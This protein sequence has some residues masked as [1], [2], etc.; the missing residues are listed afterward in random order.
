MELIY[1]TIDGREFD[2]EADA[3]YHESVLLNEKVQMFDPQGNPTSDPS[4]AMAVFLKGGEAADAFIHISGK[5][6]TD[7][8]GISSG[9]EGVYAWDSLD[10][11]YKYI[12]IESFHAAYSAL[13]AAIR[14]GWAD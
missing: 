7:A 5:T 12:E 1:R 2:N 10:S 6:G 3:C 8:T 9:D 14:E 13:S 11:E 4:Y